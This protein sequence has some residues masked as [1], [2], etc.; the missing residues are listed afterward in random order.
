M[1]KTILILVISATM[2]GLV[3]PAYA[4]DWDKFGKAMAAIEGI[5]IISGGRVDIIGTITGVRKDNDCSSSTVTYISKPHRKHHCDRVWVPRK[6]VWKKKYIP[7]HKEYSEEYGPIIVE[8]H[9]IR[10]KV[11]A[12]GYWKT[13]CNH[14]HHYKHSWYDPY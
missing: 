14:K 4:S 8:A 11:E 5:R 9:Y 12:G 6:I 2:V 1:K 13:S 3:T 7:E 10:Y